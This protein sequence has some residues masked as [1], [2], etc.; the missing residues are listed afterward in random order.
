[1]MIRKTS[2]QDIERVMDI[3]AAARAFMASD[4]NPDQWGIAYPPQNMIEDDITQ[5][6]S[7]VCEEDGVVLGVFYFRIGEDPTYLQIHDGAWLDDGDYG[8]VHRIASARDTKGV[9][10]FCLDWCFK[11]HPNIRIDTHTENKP[12]NGLLIKL[13]YKRCGTIYLQDGNPRI[14][15]HKI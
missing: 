2:Q 8:V 9:A 1:M 11:Q 7:Y 12:M 6:Y 3:Y 10:T 13:G 5:G 14:A 4:G 15:Y